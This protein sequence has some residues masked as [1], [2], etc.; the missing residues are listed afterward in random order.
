MTSHS[1][2]EIGVV[3][4]AFD[5][6]AMLAE[7]V[8]SVFSQTADSFRL[9]VVDDSSTE[10]LSEVRWLVEKRG[11][12]WLSHAEN[13]GVA[14]ARN[15]GAEAL[16]SDWIA[17]LDSD[18][19][20]DP[21]KLESQL[22]WHRSHPDC[23]IS[24]TA[25]RW[26]RMGREVRKPAGWRQK[27][28]DLFAEC[29]DRCAI[30]P[31][32]VMIRR[33]LWTEIGGFDERFPVCEDYELWLR[34]ASREPVCLVAGDPLVEKRGGHPDQLSTRVPALDRYRVV[35]LLQILERGGLGGSPSAIVRAGLAKKAKIVSSGAAK[36]SA[37]YRERFY[38]S[39]ADGL[40]RAD[41]R[42]ADWIEE[43]WKHCRD[44][45]SPGPPPRA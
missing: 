42:A 9:V 11:H 39:L 25:E 31:S 30:G 43:A 3:I 18:D 28:G 24:Q 34:I 40:G 37:A 13:R 21:K 15:T 35:A 19:L 33:D 1:I 29:V 16:A 7:A 22:A 4:P 12:L 20:W 32:C 44:E 2:S 23:R 45:Y 10:D 36:R 27:G 8:T 26:I 17:F 41:F 5:R 6:A 38:R 14:A